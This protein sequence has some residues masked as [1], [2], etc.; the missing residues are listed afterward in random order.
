MDEFDIGFSEWM[1]VDLFFVDVLMDLWILVLFYF[2]FVVNGGVD[3]CV[4]WDII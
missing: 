4:F 3:G 1:L 2:L